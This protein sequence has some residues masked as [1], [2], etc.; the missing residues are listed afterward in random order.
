M[1]CETGRSFY[2]DAG[3]RPSMSRVPRRHTPR[4]R[5]PGRT[6]GRGH[7]RGPPGPQGALPAVRRQRSGEW[8]VRTATEPTTGAERHGTSG[9]GM[10]AVPARRVWREDRGETSAVRAGATTGSYTNTMPRFA[11]GSPGRAERLSSRRS[12][13]LP[14]AL[15][16]RGR[17][18][19]R[20]GRF[21]GPS[22]P[23]GPDR[24]SGVG[25]S[26]RRPPFPRAQAE[27]P[28]GDCEPPLTPP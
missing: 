16:V 18:R 8:S 22:C 26:A 21:S 4:P 6:P 12:V 11:F 14:T 19:R 28:Q 25:R 2:P 24:P 3:G 10:A 13:P 27:R 20:T 9:R 15:R 17:P 5:A 1:S 23:A 7:S